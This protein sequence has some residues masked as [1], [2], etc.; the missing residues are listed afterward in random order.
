MGKE[1]G[2]SYKYNRSK[3]STPTLKK[4]VLSAS[5]AHTSSASN[6]ISPSISSQSDN[7][8]ITTNQKKE[9]HLTYR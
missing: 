1:S 2:R 6:S 9:Q 4:P 8:E 3:I 5:A 7:K